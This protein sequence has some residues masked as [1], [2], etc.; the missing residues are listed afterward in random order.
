[1]T[2]AFQSA[3]KYGLQTWAGFEY[4]SK[5]FWTRKGIAARVW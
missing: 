2:W 3:R 4:I 5:V 1:M